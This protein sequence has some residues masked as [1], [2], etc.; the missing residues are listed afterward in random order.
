M[1]ILLQDLLLEKVLIKKF[2][3]IAGLLILVRFYFAQGVFT[4]NYWYLDSIAQAAMMFIIFSLIMCIAGSLG[5]LNGSR[6]EQTLAFT[7]LMIILITPLGSN[8]YTYPV[9]NNL[10]LAAPISLWMFR[11]L[12]QRLGEKN[13]NFAWQGM[14]TMTI[15]VTLVQG[16]IFHAVYTFGD[17]DDGTERCAKTIIPKTAAMTTT[18][19]NAETLDQLYEAVKSK[20]LQDKKAVFFGGVPGLAYIL[21]LEPALDSVWPDL[22]SYSVAKFDNG[23]MELSVSEDPEPT[24]I[25]GRNMAEYANI[26]E[27]YDILLDYISNHDYNKVFEN[28]RFSVYAGGIESEE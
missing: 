17:G 11:R 10:F 25:V 3:F 2:L 22:D 12:M 8:N 18:E 16:V 9:I 7:A 21:D 5:F 13:Y 15:V 23:L 28:S 19:Y 4:R 1:L 24:I 14:V 6:Q 20:G 27:K 26:N